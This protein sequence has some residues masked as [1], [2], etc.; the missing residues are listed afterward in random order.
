M[1][2]KIYISH[3]RRSIEEVAKSVGVSKRRLKESIA[4]ADGLNGP[5]MPRS[6]KTSG[7]PSARKPRESTVAVTRTHMK[8][9]I[10]ISLPDPSIEDV[11]KR[12]GVSKRRLK[13]LKVIIAD[14]IESEAPRRS[15]RAG[16]QS[17]YKRSK[18]TVS[19]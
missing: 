15:Q 9:K 14:V 16:N 8:P 2:P 4:I 18:P 6:V 10:Y 11:A 7:K 3:P 13:E 12:A 5:K 17:A 1:M 19:R